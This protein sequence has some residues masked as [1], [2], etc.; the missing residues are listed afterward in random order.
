[1]VLRAII[2]TYQ[3]MP[4]GTLPN[5]DALIAGGLTAAGSMFF[6]ADYYNAANYRVFGSD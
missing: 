4:V 3:Y 1:M 6:A 2:D 5:I